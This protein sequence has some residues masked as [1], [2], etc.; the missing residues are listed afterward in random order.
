MVTVAADAAPHVGL[1]HVSRCSAIAVALLERGEEVRCVAHGATAR[2]ER[3][4]VRWEPATD[5]L[6]PAAGPVVV[7][8]YR[9][10]H[11]R[12]SALAAR[13]PV[14]WLHDGGAIPDGVALVIAPIAA[15]VPGPEWLGGLEHACLRPGYWNARARTIA[16]DVRDVLITVGAGPDGDVLGEA[17]A[18]A[19]RAALP[20]TELTLVRGPAA[21]LRA[22]DGV[23]LLVAPPSLQPALI[24]ADIVVATGGQTALEAAATGT[25]AVLLAL[26]PT[27]AEQA[28]RLE[29]AG[30]AIVA[31]DAGEAAHLVTTLG[32]E[33]RTAMSAAGRAAVDGRGAHRVA[34]R[35]SA[36]GRPGAGA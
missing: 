5:T 8:G 19:L 6:E 9:F 36:L 15:A 14:A 23:R 34:E 25:P 24:A 13:T 16:R 35:I 4:G 29:R 27:Q 30:A 1:G 31:R 32:H 20:D 11:E 26:D 17:L 21:H 3:D 10:P 18:H 7:D 28:E 2:L 22:P 33:R 12:V